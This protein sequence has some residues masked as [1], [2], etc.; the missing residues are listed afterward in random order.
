MY[1]RV[2]HG[3]EDEKFKVG[4]FAVFF[5]DESPRAAASGRE[6]DVTS[7]VSRAYYDSAEP[8]CSGVVYL[9]AG[10][11]PLNTLYQDLSKVHEIL[12]L[13][14]SVPRDEP[15]VP[16]VEFGKGVSASPTSELLG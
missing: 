5:D 3:G 9:G 4:K 11:C 1:E 7:T 8:D 10:H 2:N 14:D 16:S 6:L 15:T 12:K 13:V